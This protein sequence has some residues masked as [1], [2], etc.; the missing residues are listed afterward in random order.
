[1]R[2]FPQENVR[3]LP[4]GT[5]ILAVHPLTSVTMNGKHTHTA[6]ITGSSGRSPATTRYRVRFDVTK[7]KQFWIPYSDIV[8]MEPVLKKGD[9][10]PVASE[11]LKREDMPELTSST[12]TTDQTCLGYTNHKTASMV[13][14]LD[15]TQELYSMY[16]RSNLSS[17]G[18]LLR[19]IKKTMGSMVPGESFTFRDKEINREEIMEHLRDVQSELCQNFLHEISS[20][21]ELPQSKPWMKPAMCSY[22]R[23]TMN[24]PMLVAEREVEQF[25]STT[26]STNDQHDDEPAEVA[27]PAAPATSTTWEGVPHV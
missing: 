5:R 20:D 14:V 2:L 16:T 1:M 23:I 25:F 10:Y 13:L 18:E 17:F 11:W 24:M 7:R 12:T 3:P 4:L 6:K 27:A 21:I 9:L 26:T 22:L 15:N 19:D 8:A